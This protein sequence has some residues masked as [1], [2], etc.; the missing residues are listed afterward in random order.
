MAP[1][2]IVIGAA[3]SPA[4]HVPTFRR[5]GPEPALVRA[6]YRDHGLSRTMITSL[7]IAWPLPRRLRW[8]IGNSL[9]A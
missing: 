8:S 4:Q 2:V 3:L 5:Q 6:E 7:Q 9:L 1:L